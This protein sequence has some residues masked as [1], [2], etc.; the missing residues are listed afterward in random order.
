MKNLM[1][2]KRYTLYLLPTPRRYAGRKLILIY[3]AEIARE[4]KKEQS[5]DTN[6]E[7]IIRLAI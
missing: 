3:I 4:K 1:I 6:K 7:K 2:L 5:E